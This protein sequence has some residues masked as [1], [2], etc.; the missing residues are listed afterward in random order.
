[1]LGKHVHDESEAECPAQSA[2]PRGTH[3][4]TWC[5]TAA[6]VCTRRRPHVPPPGRVH[7]TSELASRNLE[8]SV[9]PW[10]SVAAEARPIATLGTQPPDDGDHSAACRTVAP[11]PTC[12]K[13]QQGIHAA[14]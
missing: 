10:I 11:A 13:S 8:H 2:S 3:H 14:E 6:T 4:A 5:P 7:R 1:M 9:T 12:P